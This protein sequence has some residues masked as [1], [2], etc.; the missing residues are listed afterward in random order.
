MSEEKFSLSKFIASFGQLIPW[1]KTFRFLIGSVIVILI[2]FTFWKAFFSKQQ[3]QN[4]QIVVQRG[5]QAIIQQQ[6]K[7]RR[8]LIPFMEAYVGQ[9]SKSKMNTGLRAGLRLEW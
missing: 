4:Q 6:Q 7:N 3:V 1:L 2:I 5:A 8:A 9:D